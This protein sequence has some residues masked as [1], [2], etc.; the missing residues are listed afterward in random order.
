MGKAIDD[1][2]AL[3]AQEIEDFAGVT[4]LCRS[5]KVD[6]QYPGAHARFLEVRSDMASV[7]ALDTLLF[8]KQEARLPCLPLDDALAIAVTSYVPEAGDEAG[9]ITSLVRKIQS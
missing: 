6:R 2:V 5:Q 1:D 3:R 7:D 8:H 9:A 4:E